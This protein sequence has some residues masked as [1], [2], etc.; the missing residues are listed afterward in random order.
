MFNS[1]VFTVFALLVLFELKHF[2]FD[3]AWRIDYIL[4]K[5]RKKS[6]YLALYVHSL[7]HSIGTFLIILLMT[8]NVILAMSFAVGDFSTHLGIDLW[9]TRRSADLTQADRKYWIYFGLDQLLHHVIHYVITLCTLPF[10]FQ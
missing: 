3:F 1:V 9:K 6:P 8:S 10:I 4:V 7:S 2:L 5:D